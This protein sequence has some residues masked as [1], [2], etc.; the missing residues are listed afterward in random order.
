MGRVIFLTTAITLFALSCVW[1]NLQV[2]RLQY[3][4]TDAQKELRRE[5]RSYKQM[6]IRY[7]QLRSPARLQELK[8]RDGFDFISKS[9]ARR[10]RLTPGEM[11]R[12]IR[13]RRLVS[14]VNNRS[15]AVSNQRY[16]RQR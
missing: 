11:R 1:S 2:R 5:Y 15:E 9:K 13:R 16:E 4:I 12:V 6:R 10:Q 14:G 8:K 7:E 3:E